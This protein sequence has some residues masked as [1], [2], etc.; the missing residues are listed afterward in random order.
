MLKKLI[1]YDNILNYFVNGLVIVDNVFGI[2]EIRVLFVI[3]L[4][5]FFSG[6]FF[7]YK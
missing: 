2:V 3:F 6:M 5:I 4:G 1:W 7:F